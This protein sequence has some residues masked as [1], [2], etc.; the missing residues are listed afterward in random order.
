MSRP[1]DQAMLRKLSKGKAVP[2][3][4]VLRHARRAVTYLDRFVIHDDDEADQ[5]YSSCR[6]I[7]IAFAR[8]LTMNPH[9]RP[10][11]ASKLMDTLQQKENLVN[12]PIT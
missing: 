8:I 7:R 1:L 2:F 9:R 4:V 12:G 11:I 6:D 10:K 5:L 3:E